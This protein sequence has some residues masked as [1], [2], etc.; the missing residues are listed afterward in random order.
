MNDDAAREVL[1]SN[2]PLFD[3]LSDDA[4]QLGVNMDAALQKGSDD[5]H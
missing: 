3:K 5:A 4:S 1:T 2:R